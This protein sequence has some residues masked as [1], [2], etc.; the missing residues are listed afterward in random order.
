MVGKSK[1]SS[2]NKQKIL[3]IRGLSNKEPIKTSKHLGFWFCQLE[4]TK[5]LSVYA[6]TPILYKGT[7]FNSAIHLFTYFKCSHPFFKERVLQAHDSK[8]AGFYG[9]S[10]GL[11]F[12]AN[13][14][15]LKLKLIKGWEDKAEDYMLKV[16]KLKLSQ[17]PLCLKVL[18][19]AIAT[20][21][22]LSEKD[23]NQYWSFKEVE[24]G[25]GLLVKLLKSSVGPN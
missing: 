2:S 20:G 19:D 14:H 18:K 9:S 23:P 1:K 25:N 11:T 7:V 3:Q 22:K 21:K 16:L 17:N 15:K 5:L 4:P 8:Q 10:I 12:I 13:K 24:D 6:H